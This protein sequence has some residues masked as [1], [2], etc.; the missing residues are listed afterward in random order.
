MKMLKKRINLFFILNARIA[1]KSINYNAFWPL[2][3][4]SDGDPWK[5]LETLPFL[6]SK[7]FPANLFF[8]VFWKTEQKKF[9]REK[10]LLSKT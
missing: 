3:D 8:L 10:N 2:M 7:F 6:L 4:G 1:N 5:S 9:W